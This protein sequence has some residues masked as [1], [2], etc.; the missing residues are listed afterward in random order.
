MNNAYD[1]LALKNHIGPSGVPLGG[2]GAGCFSI[3]PTGHFTRMMVGNI[4][5][6]TLPCPF[7]FSLAL[8]DGGAVNKACR[9]QRDVHEENRHPL[10]P[11][12]WDLGL[13]GCE[14]T[15]YTGLFPTVNLSFDT[16]LNLNASLFCYSGLT[17]H[18]ITLSSL[19]AAW[20]ELTV[21]NTENIDKT[22]SAA[23]SWGDLIGRG[24]K[25]QP[26]MDS[27]PMVGDDVDYMSVNGE[28]WP[29]FNPPET[30]IRGYSKDGFTGYIQY[31]KEPLEP[32]KWTY[33]NYNS[34]FLVLCENEG[35][36]LS[37]LP[38]FSP[39][40]AAK[41]WKCFAETGQF[42][43]APEFTETHLSS[44]D[45][46]TSDSALAYSF[47]LLPGETKTV[48]FLI[49]W[50]AD[51]PSIDA[52]PDR[53]MSGRDPRSYFGTADYGKYYHNIADSADTLCGFIIKSRQLILDGVNKWHEPILKSTLPDFL[54]FKLINSAYAVYS[55]SVLNKEG[56][57]TVIEG[58]MGGLGGTLDQKL[59]S[60]PFCQ[61]LFP[62]L[63]RVENRLFEVTQHKNKGLIHYILNYY[64]ALANTDGSS[65]IPEGQMMDHTGAWIIMLAKQFMQT[66]DMVLLKECAPILETS[67]E[68]LY[69]TVS[70]PSGIPVA[71]TTYDD[72]THPDIFIF[73]ASLYI[74]VLVSADYLFGKLGNNSA[75][76]KVQDRLIKARDTLNTLYNEK[77]GFY[78]LGCDKDMTEIEQNIIF[79]GQLA[80]EF[81]TRYSALSDLTG[82]EDYKKIT[83]A[84]DA[85]LTLAVG[86]CPDYYSAKLWDT[87]TQTS[88]DMPGSQC[89]PFYLECYTA[90]TAIQTGRVRDG[91]KILEHISLVHLR[92]GWSWSQNLWFPG[93]VN[94]MTT[95]VTWFLTDVLAGIAFDVTNGW[96]ALSPVRMPYGDGFAPLIRLPLFFPEFW[97]ELELDF[98]RRVGFLKVT[99]LFSEKIHIFKELH[100]HRPGEP[101]TKRDTIYL[102][103]EF[104]IA[105]DANLD[106]SPYLDKLDM[107]AADKPSLLKPVPPYIPGQTF[108][109]GGGKGL[110]L[111][112]YAD[113]QYRKRICVHENTEAKIPECDGYFIM[114]GFIVPRYSNA[115]A[116]FLTGTGHLSLSL[117]GKIV[118]DCIAEKNECVKSGMIPLIAG[119][120]YP[121]I[122]KGQGGIK[123]E[124]LSTMQTREI[125]PVSFLYDSNEI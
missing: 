32:V 91:L 55:N 56:L 26:N 1:Y 106:L 51:P 50:Y 58:L 77:M 90:M 71:Y 123:L 19:P 70:E 53:A 65:P 21:Q 7:G 37:I 36:K 76:K 92:N 45:K 61:K 20:L 40:D 23:L 66:G 97:C 111:E 115:Y 2:I 39:S 8:Y 113:A 46:D 15:T 48:R 12:P 81:L 73:A 75:S 116:L 98:E 114:S 33:Q 105:K 29:A 112:I 49:M 28:H 30:Y 117:D 84:L 79:S 86:Q 38:R 54:K 47:S 9:L 62:A 72:H 103:R 82:T 3:S 101:L 87:S 5:R 11:E 95:P 59:A 102:D 93:P 100:I 14:S 94:Y 78:S 44:P 67:L 25:D 120:R 6:N 83:S 35:D 110:L 10:A 99:E 119:E 16:P 60:H 68:W 104:V 107:Y 63:D 118:L 122:I 13:T 124:W 57:F 4:Q 109:W 89:W 96:L 34:S 31:A 64:G 88:L 108:I 42:P 69:S 27:L 85:M 52:Y 121:I 125:V 17:P 74:A 24:L 41:A 80:G 18:D 22:I 43:E